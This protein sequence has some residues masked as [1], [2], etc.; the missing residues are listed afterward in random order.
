MYRIGIDLGGTNIAA[1]IVNEEFKIVAKAS[2]PTRAER[3]AE[4][5]V[6]DI[7]TL[8]RDVCAKA[9]IDIGEVAS[10]GIA[11]PGIVSDESGEA[12]YANNLPFHHLPILPMLREMLPI[13]E[14]I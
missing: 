10:V 8:C 4:E 3:A 9:N 6:A 1:G 7:A 12:I 2:V 13:Y 5:I 14:Q 11:S